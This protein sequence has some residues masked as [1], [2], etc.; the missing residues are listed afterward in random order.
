MTV[1]LISVFLKCR[2]MLMARKKAGILSVKRD[3]AMF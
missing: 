1:N 3:E 2:N